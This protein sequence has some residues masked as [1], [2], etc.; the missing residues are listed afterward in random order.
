MCPLPT[1]EVFELSDER[2]SPHPPRRAR[3]AARAWARKQRDRDQRQAAL[4]DPARAAVRPATI[5][6]RDFALATGLSCATIY[7]RIADGSLKSTKFAGRRLIAWSEIQR[8]Q[9]E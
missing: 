1:D 5:S 4:N 3:A 7:R 2:P 9:G 6:I 8:L